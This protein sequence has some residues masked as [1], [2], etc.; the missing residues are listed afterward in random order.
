MSKK[1]LPTTMNEFF[2]EILSVVTCDDIKKI[3][4]VY[5][6]NNNI[7]FEEAVYELAEKIFKKYKLISHRSITEKENP[8]PP[9]TYINGPGF[10][11][12]R[13]LLYLLDNIFKKCNIVKEDIDTLVWNTGLVMRKYA[14]ENKD[15]TIDYL[16]KLFPKEERPDNFES[17]VKH[18]IKVYDEFQYSTTLFQ[19]VYHNTK[20]NTKFYLNNLQGT[21]FMY[22]LIGLDFAF[23]N[24]F[25][26]DID[27]KQC[28]GKKVRRKTRKRRNTK[29]VC[30]TRKNKKKRKIR[31]TRK[32]RKK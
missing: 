12:V 10:N 5:S 21:I 4:C 2:E 14:N 26:E 28:G 29:K 9:P 3:K 25:Y 18:P 7:D 20:D 11:T 16:K 19:D 22:L 30:K 13:F 15:I 1:K 17:P 31:K 32:G 23:S 8:N 24:D 6:K 27:I